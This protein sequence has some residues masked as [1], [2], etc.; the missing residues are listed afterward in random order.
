MCESFSTH[1][2]KASDKGMNKSVI[3]AA[4]VPGAQLAVFVISN[5][6]KRDILKLA[7]SAYSERFCM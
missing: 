7:E 4:R 3:L 5:S 6:M 2:H 1:N